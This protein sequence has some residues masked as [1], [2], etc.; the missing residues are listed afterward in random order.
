MRSG[1]E[2]VIL[3]YNL[4]RGETGLVRCGGFLIFLSVVQLVCP[5][6]WLCDLTLERYE[7]REKKIPKKVSSLLSESQDALFTFSGRGMPGLTL[8]STSSGEISNG[9]YWYV[10]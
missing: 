9:P 10:L 3:N 1:Y 6:G 8:S 4:L 7:V 2:Q 5:G